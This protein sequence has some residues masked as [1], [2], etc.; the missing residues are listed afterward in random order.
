VSQAPNDRVGQ[1][2]NGTARHARN[3]A[4][5]SPLLFGD[6]AEEFIVHRARM[7]NWKGGVFGAEADS[8]RRTLIR[9]SLAKIPIASITTADVLAVLMSMPKRPERESRAFSIGP[10]QWAIANHPRMSRVAAA[11]WNTC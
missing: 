11:T 8:Y 1:L 2:G 5:R 7:K 3:D 9:T 10:R 6:A 4:G